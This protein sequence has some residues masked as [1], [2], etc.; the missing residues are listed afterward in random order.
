MKLDQLR[1]FVKVVELGS[2]TAAADAVFLTQP[3]VSRTIKILEEDLGVPIFERKNRRLLLNAAG[4][5][6]LPQARAILAATTEA[7]ESVR[8]AFGRGYKSLRLGTI[9]SAG[10]YVLPSVLLDLQADFP[11]LS[12]SVR[13]NRSAPL[14]QAVRT[15]QIDL[16]IV[17]GNTPP[18]GLTATALAPYRVQYMG[19]REK[20]PNLAKVRTEDAL[21]EFPL[22]ELVALPGQATLVGDDAAVI[23]GS[24]ASLKRFVVEG[25]AVG[26][27]LDFMLDEDERKE[28]VTAKIPHSP[29]C[30]LFLVSSPRW[31]AIAPRKLTVT[32]SK[33]LRAALSK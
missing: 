10:I 4:E 25:F 30:K 26:G 28:L 27:M 20:F 16:A 6:L 33:Q 32:V 19:R 18:P 29:G 22:V 14:L 13:T 9:D 31:M 24:L 17:A 2:V 23:A 3:A 7:T 5:T 1:I 15:N 12:I 21:V 11:E 8:D